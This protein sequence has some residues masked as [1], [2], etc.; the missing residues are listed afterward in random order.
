MMTSYQNLTEEED[1]IR[2][3]INGIYASV[4]KDSNNKN[5]SEMRDLKIIDADG[6]ILD[7]N[8]GDTTI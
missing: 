3:L 7:E 1:S 8:G 2:V 6:K 5:F 4:P